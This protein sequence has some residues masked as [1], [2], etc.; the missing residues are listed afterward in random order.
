MQKIID[1]IINQ[2][3]QTVQGKDKEVKLALS[4]FISR[5]HLLLEDYPGV[6]KTTLAKAL[7]SVLG[8]DFKRLQCT[9]DLMPSDIVGV[10][11]YDTKE[12]QFI[13]KK[14]P[15]FSQVLLADEINR[16]TPKTQ[17]ALLEAMEERQVSADGTSHPLWEHFFVIG[18]KN[19]YDE[20]GTFELP[21][22]QLDRFTLSMSVGYPSSEA[23]KSILLDQSIKLNVKPLEAA[24]I[25]K[26]FVAHDSV[27][28]SE[29]IVEHIQEILKV[30][31]ESGA[32]RM[33][34]STRAAISLREVCKAWAMI[35]GRDYVV[36]EDVKMMLPFVV[37]HRLEPVEGRVNR[38]VVADEILKNHH[39]DT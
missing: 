5:G 16:T 14:G 8:L 18:T 1:N 23:E 34:L 29:K 20:R 3:S 26:L 27:K 4:C 7:A 24:Y 21:Q 19:P 2:V 39:W 31:R 37:G 17:S 13:F 28:V 25:D 35:E 15:I 9:S 33:G 12:A 6:G 36:P 30:T 11:F 32:Y 38:D 10:N 22:S